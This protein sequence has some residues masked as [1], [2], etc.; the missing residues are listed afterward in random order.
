VTSLLDSTIPTHFA[1]DDDFAAYVENECT[2]LKKGS[3]RKVYASKDGRFVVKRAINKKKHMI[4]NWIEVAAFL[5]FEKDR[6]KLGVIRS[7]SASG[8]FLVMERLDMEARP[9]G[10]FPYP[11]WVSDRKPKNIGK[12]EDGAYRICD[13]AV[14]NVPGNAQKSDFA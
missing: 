6:P 1:C 5:K 12:G 3:S 7:W 14:I 4:C 9:T 8:R 13:Y 10:S 2:F 11:T